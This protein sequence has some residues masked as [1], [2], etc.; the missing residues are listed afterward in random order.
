[1]WAGLCDVSGGKR[2]EGSPAA[3]AVVSQVN[4]SVARRRR[5]EVE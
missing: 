4:A 3:D 1:M 2:A 5:D